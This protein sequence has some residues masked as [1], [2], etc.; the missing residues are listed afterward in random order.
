[1]SNYTYS[2]DPESA[3]KN[4]IGALTYEELEKRQAPLVSMRNA[5]IKYGGGPS[6][7]FDAAH[8]KAIHHHLFQDGYEWA[9]RTRV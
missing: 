2:D 6:G 4:K 9:G 1:M 3:I 8:L 5:E 7:N